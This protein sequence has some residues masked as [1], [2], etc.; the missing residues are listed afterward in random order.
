VAKA[1][2]TSPPGFAMSGRIPPGFSR[3]RVEQ[4][5]N[6]SGIT[7]HGSQTTPLILTLS[8]VFLLLSYIL[9]FF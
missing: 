6:S 1:H 3:G 9:Y 5:C 7:L 4:S 2:A 8:R